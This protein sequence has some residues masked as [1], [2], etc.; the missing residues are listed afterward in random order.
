MRIF[1]RW[2]REKLQRQGFRGTI[3]ASAVSGPAGYDLNEPG[4]SCEIIE[5]ERQAN[6]ASRSP[7]IL[8]EQQRH[9]WQPA[10]HASNG[11]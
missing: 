1:A 4:Q 7:V 11:V 9:V 8:L 5:V 3:R 2:A 10:L 6:I